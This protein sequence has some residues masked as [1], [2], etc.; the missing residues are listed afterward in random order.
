MQPAAAA[1]TDHGP[2]PS[3]AAVQIEG[4]CSMP[5]LDFETISIKLTFV[6][7]NRVTTRESVMNS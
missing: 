1:I 2:S 3:P 4:R 5:L 6:P 7:Y